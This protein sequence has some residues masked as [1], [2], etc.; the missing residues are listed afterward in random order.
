VKLESTKW[1]CKRGTNHT[2][3]EAIFDHDDIAEATEIAAA[4]MHYTNSHNPGG[5]VR[6]PE[7]IKNRIIAGKLADFAV[8]EMISR[9]IDRWHLGSDFQVF[10]Y[11]SCRTDN[12]EYRDPCDLELTNKRSQQSQTIEVRSSFC[13]RLAPVT[14]ITEKLSVYGWYTSENKPIE[15]PRDWYFQV[16]YYLRPRDITDE[17]GIKVDIFEDRIEADS[18]TAYVVGGASQEMLHNKGI[19]RT[20]QDG[21]N[22]QAIFPICQANDCR[23]MLNAIFGRNRQTGR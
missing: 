20:D 10:E 21:A 14:K 15:P 18:V 16:V 11:D 8:R 5:I 2:V 13:Y 7:V 4:K 1:P 19:N 17:R 9:C 22:Y 12:F 6:P 3:V 23:A